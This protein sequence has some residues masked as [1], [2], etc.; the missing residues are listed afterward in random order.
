MCMACVIRVKLCHGNCRYGFPFDIFHSTFFLKI[1]KND[2][3]MN[4][5]SK[6]FH[7]CDV[8]HKFL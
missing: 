8:R 7:E 5:V 6:M 1:D 4:I 2:Y 3:H